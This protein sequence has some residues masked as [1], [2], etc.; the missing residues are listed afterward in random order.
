MKSKKSLLRTLRKV[1]KGE[2]LTVNY[3]S[4]H[5]FQYFRILEFFILIYVRTYFITLKCFYYKITQSG[6]MIT[7]HRQQTTYIHVLVFPCLVL[8]LLSNDDV[9]PKVLLFSPSISPVFFISMQSNMAG[10]ISTK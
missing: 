10:C 7:Y 8:T 9:V 3:L 5:A 1:N 2:E 6:K 4:D